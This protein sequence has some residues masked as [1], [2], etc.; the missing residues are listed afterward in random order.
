[1]G[2]SV[3]KG[4]LRAPPCGIDR[5]FISWLLCSDSIVAFGSNR[6]EP[7]ARH[8]GLAPAARGR[9]VYAF[10]FLAARGWVAGNLCDGTGDVGFL[11]V[12][13]GVVC[14]AP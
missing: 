1:M 3:P 13:E 4:P 2:G 10:F 14:A 9:E 7:H 5:P 8:A 11:G 6:F 12:F